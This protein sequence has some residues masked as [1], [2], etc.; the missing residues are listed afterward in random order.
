MFVSLPWDTRLASG[1]RAIIETVPLDPLPRKPETGRF[2]IPG[3]Q[4]PPRGTKLS[5]TQINRLEAESLRLD[6]EAAAEFQRGLL[7]KDL[8]QVPGYEFGIFYRGARVVSGDHYDFF[9]RPDGRLGVVIGDASGKGVAAAMLSAMMRALLHSVP[10]EARD[11]PDLLL[12]A[13]NV[14]LH[15][16]VRRGMFISMTY[17]LLDPVR[18]VMTG[19]NAGH[20]PTLVWRSRARL[21]T[22]HP[23]R[24]V[25]LG[26]GGA[27]VFDAR[28]QVEEIALDPGDRVVLLTDGVNEAMAP[29]AREFGMEHLR[30]RLMVDGDRASAELIRNITAQIDIHRGG[31][32]QSDDITIVTFRRIA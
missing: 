25:V 24:G 9:A 6:A 23:A 18:H 27:E 5:D 8:P 26:A 16:Q 21:V 7:P 13:T 1:S 11:R 30:R 10:D 12:S 14:L 31:G 2:A 29:G 22:V 17:L 20:L 32:E 4:T 3:S 19:V 28:L 15:P